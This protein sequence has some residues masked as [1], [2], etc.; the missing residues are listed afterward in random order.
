[1]I[2]VRLE[3]PLA[4]TWYVLAGTLATFAIGTLASE[5]TNRTPRVS[6]DDAPDVAV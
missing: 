6:N 3:T 4:W 2:V 5:M 1:M